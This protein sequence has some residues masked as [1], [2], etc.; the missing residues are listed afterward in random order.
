MDPRA[1]PSNR[2][3]LQPASVR[4]VED[5]VGDA[6]VQRLDLVSHDLDA[7]LQAAARPPEG[8]GDG[9]LRVSEPFVEAGRAIDIHCG[10]AGHL[11]VDG[12]LVRNA[13]AMIAVRYL[14]HHVAGRHATEEVL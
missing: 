4:L 2:S 12:D 5:A 14:E 3:P 8:V 11:D 7:I 13:G 1:V 10:A 9:K 6:L